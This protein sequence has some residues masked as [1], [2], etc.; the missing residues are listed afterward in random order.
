[1]NGKDKCD[2]LNKIRQKIA[3]ANNIDFV[4][5]DCNFKG[6]CFGT[7]PKSDSELQYLENELEKKQNDGEKIILKG[8]FTLDIDEKPKK[9]TPL[10]DIPINRNPEKLESLLNNPILSNLPP[11]YLDNLLD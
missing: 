10:E 3:D 7:C 1:M 2:L 5:Y 8:I 9:Q 6:E 11:R 4:I